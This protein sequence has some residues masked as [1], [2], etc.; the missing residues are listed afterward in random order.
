MKRVFVSAL[1]TT[2][3]SG[4]TVFA[5][6]SNH[7]IDALQTLLQKKV[8]QLEVVSGD[9]VEPIVITK[10]IL[11][12]TSSSD[13]LGETL[14]TYYM[15]QPVPV[16]EQLTLTEFNNI[17]V[18]QYFG[19]TTNW[20]GAGDLNWKA[21]EQLIPGRTGSNGQYFLV[22]AVGTGQDDFIQ[23]WIDHNSDVIAVQHGLGVK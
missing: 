8:T 15:S 19:P 18:G 11:P 13:V 17:H 20:A 2:A 16:V 5:F 23:V 6:N 10:G 3:L 9:K 14:F 7:V 22:K 12:D 1:I 4:A 21:I